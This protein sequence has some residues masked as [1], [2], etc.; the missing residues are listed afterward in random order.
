MSIPSPKTGS[1]ALVTGASSGIGRELARQLCGRGHDVIIVARRRERLDELAQ[2]L[3]TAHGRRVEVIACDVSDPDARAELHQ[4]VQ[5]LGLT[6]D[7]LALAAGFGLGGEFV[8]EEVPRIRLMIR[9]N[10]EGT[11]ELAHV[12]A[13]E[14]AARGTGAI[15][16]LSS[17]AGEQPMVNF[18]VY[19]ATKAALTSFSE[20]LHTELRPHGVTV[21]VVCPGGVDTEFAQIADMVRADHRMRAIRMTPQDCATAAL[22]ALERGERKHIPLLRVRLVFGISKVIPRGLW[23]RIGQRMAS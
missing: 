9:T 12:C 13:S 11:I 7:V 15:L 6:I 18:A 3:R 1:A 23:L 14:M 17:I 4:A 20:A 8:A 19:G 2:E 5:D 21:T 10:V 22:S 16:I